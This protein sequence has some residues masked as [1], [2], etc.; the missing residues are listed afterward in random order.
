M[1]VGVCDDNFDDR[2]EIIRLIEKQNSPVPVQILSF[3]TIYE[4]EQSKQKPDVLF[5]DIEIGEENGIE[6]VQRLSTLSLIPVIVLVSS[7]S[8]YVTPAFTVPVVQ[9]LLK[10][11]Q[12]ELFA[13][14]F[15]DC[16]KR[17]MQLQQY[18]EVS[19]PN[20][21]KRIFPLNQIVYIKSKSR[22]LIYA[23]IYN[24]QYYGTEGLQA[25]LTR[26]QPFGF[27]QIHKSY[28]VNLLFVTAITE[29]RITVQFRNKEKSLPVGKK[30]A[31]TLKQRYLKY[32]AIKGVN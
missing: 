28:L 14:V 4:L 24:R 26:L 15:M 17:Y 25:T 3:S 21:T 23:D 31:S 30:Y 13:K 16:C 10:P 1:F 12:Q 5:L 8:Y 20:R 9:F 6:Y 32:L 11:V 7:H 22:H 18:C 29:E 27:C 2:K 19:L